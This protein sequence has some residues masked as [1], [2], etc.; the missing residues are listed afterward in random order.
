[1]DARADAGLAQRSA[2]AVAVVE[3]D[4][5]QVEDALFRR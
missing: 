4:R 2:D 1:V 5:E 3:L